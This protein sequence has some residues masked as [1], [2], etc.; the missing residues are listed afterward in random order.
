VVNIIEDKKKLIETLINKGIKDKRVLRAIYDV[1][2]EDFVP[3]D[4]KPYAYLDK[5]LPI[6]CLQTISQP[7]TVAYMTEK[8]KIKSSDHILEIGTGSG[9]QTAILACI[10]KKIYTIERI[11]ALYDKVKLR[12]MDYNSKICFKLADGT[13]GWEENAPFDKIIVTAAAPAVPPELLNQLSTN[14]RMIIPVG[15][16]D[17]QQMLLIE[18]KNGKVFQKYLDKFKFVPLIGKYGWDK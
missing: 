4:I 8:L 18:K 14:G 11:S 1:P 15:E 9:Y 17:S 7:Y 6:D 3:D 13:T 5:A 2:R 16:R 12:L 10:A